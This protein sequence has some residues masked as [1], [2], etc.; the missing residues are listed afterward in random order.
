MNKRLAIIAA[1][2]FVM[3]MLLSEAALAVSWGRLV[4]ETEVPSKTQENLQKAVDAV[5]KIFTKYK[6]VINNP[7]NMVVAANNDESYIQALMS[8]GKISRVQAENILKSVNLGLSNIE[9]PLIIIRYYPYRQATGQGTSYQVHPPEEGFHTLPHEVFHQVQNQY[10][11]QYRESFMNW[12][13]EG[14]AELFK[15][16]SI[17]AAGIRFVADSIRR[18]EHKIRKAGKIPDTRQLASYDYKDWRYLGQ[19]KYPIYEMATVMTYR[20]VGDDGFAQLLFYYKLLDEGVDPDKA[21]NNAFNRR[22]SDFLTEMKHHFN[23]FRD[24]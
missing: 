15:L 9:K 17:E 22:M 18:Y 6:I 21:F 8:H 11:N 4:Y 24:L 12:L 19:Q 13:L 16:V 2:I 20:L 5:D 1:G 7:I 3:H 10:R 23:E 14:P